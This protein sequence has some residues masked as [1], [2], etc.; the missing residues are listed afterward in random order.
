MSD[1]DADDDTGSE[2]DA[3]VSSDGAAAV[4]VGVK[5]GAPG[6]SL[7]AGRTRHGD[8]IIK[9]LTS[10]ATYEDALTGDEKSSTAKKQPASITDA[11]STCSV[12]APSTLT[13][14]R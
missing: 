6:P 4:P 7:P 5:P 12:G 14:P 9:T 2:S 1:E 8:Q 13:G 11:S 3:G 10:M